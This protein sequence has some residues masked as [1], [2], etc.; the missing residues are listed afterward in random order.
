MEILKNI[1]IYVYTGAVTVVET[2][3]VR[4]RYIASRVRN[5]LP[6]TSP[7]CDP[8]SLRIIIVSVHRVLIFHHSLYHM[9]TRIRTNLFT[10]LCE[11]RNKI[12]KNM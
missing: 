4:G 11:N 5:R 12:M 2:P 1:Y 9:Q 3:R 6:L 8:T 7:E 10:L